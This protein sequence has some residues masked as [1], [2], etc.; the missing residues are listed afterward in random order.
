[1]TL[2]TAKPNLPW[3]EAASHRYLYYGLAVSVLVH[4]GLLALRFQAPPAAP[5]LRDP[6]LEVVLLNTRSTEQP[7]APTVLAQT[8]MDGGGS[9]DTGVAR[10]PL[11]PSSTDLSAIPN[12]LTESTRQE[13]LEARQRELLSQL[14][15]AQAAVLAAKGRDDALAP[16][17]GTRPDA[18]S[19]H[20]QLAQQIAAVSQRIHDYNRQPRRHF[21]APSASAWRYAEYVEA[22]RERVEQIG[23]AHYPEAAR[24]RYYGTVQV[25]VFIHADGSVEKLEFD[26]PSEHAVLNAAVRDIVRRAA[27]FPV[28]PDAIRRDTD[29]LAI[30][31]TWH[32]QNDAIS[33]EISP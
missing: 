8:D 21:F 17:S 9:H 1:M 25:T 33:T 29:I 19:E 3:R 26:A 12:A 16:R 30:T 11:P 7:L 22:W 31:R 6:G 32:F 18:Q 10:S 4:S 24:G 20:A 14:R 27:P 15:A 2:T 13:E 5:A 28:F 23:N